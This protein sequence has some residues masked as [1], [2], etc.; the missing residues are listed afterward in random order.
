[1]FERPNQIDAMPAGSASS[2]SPGVV[3]Q[4]DRMNRPMIGTTQR[5]IVTDKT[6]YMS[7]WRLKYF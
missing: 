6:I 1:L 5:L 2:F 3:L 7:Q 4:R